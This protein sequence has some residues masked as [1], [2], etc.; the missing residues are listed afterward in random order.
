MQGLTTME[1][2]SRRNP[3]VVIAVGMAVALCIF[4]VPA[5]YP[6]DQPAP[7][8]QAPEGAP[9]GPLPTLEL[10]I[11]GPAKAAIGSKAT[12]E[13]VIT[14]AGKTAARG[15]L[16]VDHFD[17]GLEHAVGQSPIERPLPDLAPGESQRLG[18]TFRIAQSGRLAHSVEITSGG[19]VVASARSSV[20]VAGAKQEPANPPAEPEKAEMPPGVPPGIKPAPGSAF[21]EI[22]P[23][24]DAQLERERSEGAFPDL[25]P[26]LVDNAKE[27]TR[28][29]PEFPI[30]V[31]RKNKRVVVLGAVCSRECP[32]E[33]FACLWTS[34]D[35]ESV[36]S[37]PGRA[38]F[39]HAGLLAVGAESG[40]PVQFRPKYVPA[41]G[42]EIEVTVVWNDQQGKRQTARA[43]DWVR[44]VKTKKAMTQPWVFGGSGIRKDPETGEKAYYADLT[45]ELIC[46]SN[47]ASAML[48][49]PIESTSSDA[50]LMF[51]TFTERIPPRGT[52]VTLIL[53]PKLKKPAEGEP[54]A[55][56][57]GKAPAKPEAKPAEAA[58]PAK[59]PSNSEAKPAESDGK[60]APPPKAPPKEKSA[61]PP[62]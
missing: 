33:L 45:G 48:D 1:L 20:S 28:L 49:L 10:K 32:L 44:E 23:K 50:E 24:T 38:S 29:H 60:S 13:L 62:E 37:V 4:C 21:P 56:T 25:G 12:F 31:D 2:L 8:A 9:R 54:P 47:F 15:L 58:P 19:K 30:W 43:Q 46:V 17:Q 26:P 41:R 18:L 57:P 39:V 42:P 59:T 55:K 7:P 6:A 51:E 40:S 11:D 27:L 16:V 35:Y 22:K 5:A 61:S 52:P 53:T 14:N 36:V 34:K 3:F